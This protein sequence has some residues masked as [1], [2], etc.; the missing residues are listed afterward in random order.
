MKTIGIIGGITWHSTLEYYRQINQLVNERLGGVSSAKIVLVSLNFEKIKNWTE[1]GDWASISAEVCDA[2]TKLEAAGAD[3]LLIGANT[4]HKI[5]DHVQAVVHIPLIHIADV[6]VAAIS[7]QGLSTVLL[8]GTKYTME[9]DFYK[10]KLAAAGIRTIIPDE[11]A[12][13]SINTSIYEEM[14]KGIFLPARKIEFL[15]I[16]QQFAAA[17]AQGVILGCTEIP[18]LLQGETK[19]IPDFDTLL[20]HA[21]AAVDFAL[22]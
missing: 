4:M 16:M 19:P 7:K 2:A 1:A 3:C 10:D 20:L 21:T 5:A 15:Q 14:G 13:N 8:L 11:G 12:R 18:V 9:L 6:A 17:G 22:S